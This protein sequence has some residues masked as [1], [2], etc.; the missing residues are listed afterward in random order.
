[1]PFNIIIRIS[2]RLQ[3]W[4]KNLTQSRT[5]VAVDSNFIKKRKEQLSNLFGQKIAIN[6]YNKMLILVY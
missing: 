5:D 1:M 3:Q 4:A 2:N 6:T